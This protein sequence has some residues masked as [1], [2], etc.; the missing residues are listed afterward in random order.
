MSKYQ[1]ILILGCSMRKIYFATALHH[2]HA[3]AVSKSK[4]RDDERRCIPCNL[5][6]YECRSDSVNISVNCIMKSKLYIPCKWK[7]L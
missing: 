4:K 6:H 1:G 3:D 7:M 2:T 5:D